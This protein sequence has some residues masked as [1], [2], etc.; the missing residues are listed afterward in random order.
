M[1]KIYLACLVWIVVCNVALSQ[2]PTDTTAVKKKEVTASEKKV[3]KDAE[4]AEQEKISESSEKKADSEKSK[5]EDTTEVKDPSVSANAD[6]TKEA[7]KTDDSD[8]PE[9]PFVTGVDETA[10]SET[11]QSDD[12]ETPENPFLTGEETVSVDEPLDETEGGGIDLLVD[13][14]LGVSLSRFFIEPE[15]LT[16]EGK[17]SFLFNPGV[18]IPFAKRFFAGIS[19][20]YM[21]ISVDLSSSYSTISDNYPSTSVKTYTNEIMTFISVP[22]KLGMRFELSK[23]IPYFYADIEPAYLT[24]SNQFI[25]EE[26]H[27]VFTDGSEYFLP[28]EKNTKDMETTGNRKREQIFVGGGIGIEFP[29]GYGSVYIDGGCKYGV[30]DTDISE[31]QGHSMPWRNASSVIYFP[32][33]LGIRFFL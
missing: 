1:K 4:K 12:S 14:G 8:V 19:V 11:E 3:K 18:I 22:L 31:A 24:G 13:L 25:S 17:P 16:T 23:I 2:N 28:G 5:T 32:V 33:S 21:Q 26:I 6:T 20:R 15:D 27:T 9:N 30:F 7:E 10:V 29:Y